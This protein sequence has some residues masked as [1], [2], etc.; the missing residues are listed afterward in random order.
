MKIIHICGFL[1]LLEICYMYDVHIK[2]FPVASGVYQKHS[3]EYL[4]LWSRLLKPILIA[5]FVSWLC[6]N[7]VYHDSKHPGVDPKPVHPASFLDREDLPSCCSSLNF[8]VALS[9]GP[10]VALA[11]IW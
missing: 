6:W 9:M 2:L 3:E 1:I 10:L 4:W 11:F 8:Y 7:M 5:S